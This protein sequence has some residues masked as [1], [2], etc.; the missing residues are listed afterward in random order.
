MSIV[1]R[2][3]L[4]IITTAAIFSTPA[5]A[6]QLS[7]QEVQTLTQKAMDGD[8]TAQTDLANRYDVGDGID[9]DATQA[10]FWYKKLANKGIAKAQLALG[11]KYIRGEGIARDDKQAVHWLSLAAE[12]RLALAQYL[13]GVAHAEGHGVERDNVKAYMWYEIA[14][15][16]DHQDAIEARTALARQMTPMD[17][18]KAEKMAN[19][20]WL[21]FH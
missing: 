5:L 1:I 18:K 8:L 20:W 15:A 21:K 12:Q 9:R 16:M 10:A 2:H 19:D 3:L 17:I 7:K 6:A 4:T 11:L 13:L 14:A